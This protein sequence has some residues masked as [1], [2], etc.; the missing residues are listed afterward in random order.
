MAPDERPISEV[1]GDIAQNVQQI[2]RAE[3]RLAKAELLEDAARMRRGGTFMAIAAIAGALSVGCLCLTVIFAL[4]LVLPGWAAAL[5][6]GVLMAV[7]AGL[8][9]ASGRRQLAGLG[10]PRT[11]AAVKEN[12]QWAKTR[13]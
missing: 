9:L 3:L 2:A 7:V 6:V 1:L 12:V 5:I 4:T 8:C 10:M 13:T 11:A